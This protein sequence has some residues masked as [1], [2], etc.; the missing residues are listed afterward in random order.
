MWL[1]ERFSKFCK[2]L[3][4]FCFQCRVIKIDHVPFT[5]DELLRYT[6][7]ITFTTIVRI[8]VFPHAG[9]CVPGAAQVL[10]SASSSFRVISELRVT[11]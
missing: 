1:L 6:V 7:I 8:S 4:E 9:F 3:G 5:E 2:F 10:V 11:I